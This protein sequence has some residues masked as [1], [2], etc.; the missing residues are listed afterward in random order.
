MHHLRSA[1]VPI[2]T[3][4]PHPE[5][6]RTTVARRRLQRRG[7]PVGLDLPLGRCQHLV[8]TSPQLRPL[9]AVPPVVV[10]VPVEDEH[11]L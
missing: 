7:S 10:V 3:P 8:D 6:S 5:N 11:V 1:G 4:F 2:D 9:I